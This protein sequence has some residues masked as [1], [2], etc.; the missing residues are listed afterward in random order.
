MVLNLDFV[1]K[2]WSLKG[3]V[4]LP[5]ENQEYLAVAGENEDKWDEEDLAVEDGVVEVSPLARG[6]TNP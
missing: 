3:E 4:S 1:H 6:Q 5:S 2:E